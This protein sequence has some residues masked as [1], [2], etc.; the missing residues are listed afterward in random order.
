ME[1]GYFVDPLHHPGSDYT[2]NIH[3]DLQQIVLLDELGYVEAW[4]AEHF[5]AP[6]ENI[7]SPELFIAQALGMTKNIKLATGVTCLPNHNPFHLA[8]RI[9]QLDHQAKGRFMWGI[10]SGAT[11][12]DFKAFG[13]DAAS[14]EQR[15]LTWETLEMVLKIWD[16][17][18]PGTYE[19][20]FWK[21]TIPEPMNDIGFYTHMKPYTL[22]HPPI[23]VA[24]MSPRSES[25]SVAGERGWMPL[26]INFVP[27]RTLKAQWQVYSEA[28]AKAGRVADR[29][30][31]RI[32]RDVVVADTTEDAR[33]L[34]LSGV[35]A[36]DFEVYFRQVMDKLGFLKFMKQDP[37][38]PDDDID[39]DYMVD[40]LW[41]V[42]TPDEVA[43]QIRK[44][45][46]DV[47]GFG[48]ML[49]YSHEW[50]PRDEWVRSMTLLANEVMPRLSDL[51]MAPV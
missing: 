29:A 28:A 12:T 18:E 32:C 24:G 15:D 11:P 45:H 9:A 8:H 40:N 20:K 50:E 21:F 14:N 17:L 4:I 46:D 27:P 30:Q 13:I 19:N 37:E 2:K 23:A 5:T 10:G 42:G 49:A 1:L 22:P 25:L 6:W 44:L 47:G 16:G 3:D 43:D 35:M 41:I 7:P 51:E 33:K 31:W 36:R 34:A 48:V 39:L 38:T 26:G